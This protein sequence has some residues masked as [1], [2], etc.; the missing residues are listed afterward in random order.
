[1]IRFSPFYCMKPDL[2]EHMVKFALF[3]EFYEMRN[4]FALSRGIICM[5]LFQCNEWFD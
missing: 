2:I 3:G 1:M 5:F 4:Q